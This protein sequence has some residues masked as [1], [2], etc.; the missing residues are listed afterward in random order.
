MRSASAISSKACV[1]IQSLGLLDRMRLAFLDGVPDPLRQARK[2][3]R[4]GLSCDF[5]SV[6]EDDERRN[7]ADAETRRDLRRGLRVELGEA[8]LGLERRC[9]LLERRGHHPARPAPLCPEVYDHG[10]II[11]SRLPIE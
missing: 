2:I 4:A 11:R 8:S 10:K 3:Q 9:S 1:H 5:T 7:A 6:L